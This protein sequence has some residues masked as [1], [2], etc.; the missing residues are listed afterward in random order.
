MQWDRDGRVQKVSFWKIFY[1]ECVQNHPQE[2]IT[3]EQWSKSWAEQSICSCWDQDTRQGAQPYL[4]AG[5]VSTRGHS[6]CWCTSLLPHSP[7]FSALLHRDT[8]MVRKDWVETLKHHKHLCCRWPWPNN[9][10]IHFDLGLHCLNMISE[11]LI[12]TF[13]QIISAGFAGIFGFELR[14][15]SF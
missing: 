12:W 3:I 5:L 14:D 4:L 13:P 6:H 8:F 9:I 11:N 1:D 10:R 15:I 2:I 7:V